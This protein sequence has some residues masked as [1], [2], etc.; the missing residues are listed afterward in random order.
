MLNLRMHGEPP[1]AVAVVHGGPGARGEMAPVAR[2]LAGTWGVLE[3]LQTATTIDGQVQELA[4]ALQQSGDA[5]VALVGFSWGAWLSTLVAARHAALVDRLILVGCGPFEE[6]HVSKIQETRLARLDEAAR[7]EYQSI[8]Q[9]LADPGAVG[10]D[11]AFARLG[12]LAFKTD[13]FDPIQEAA[14]P[15]GPAPGLRNPFHRVL[16][17]AQEMRRTG[18]LLAE[19][20]R[21]VC[22]VL[23]IHGDYDPHPAA[24]VQEPLAATLASF[25]LILL[26]N[27]GHKPWIERQA[28]D[29]FYDALRCAL[30]NQDPAPGNGLPDG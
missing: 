12:D 6:K 9:L 8:L 28:R 3:P 29:R 15:S 11:A 26:Q 5:P 19:A 18:R 4:T 13:G 7:A 21:V 17:Q 27:C 23:A 30:S 1:Y 14:H 24:G 16:A 25:R 20:S 2:E 22:P 10:R